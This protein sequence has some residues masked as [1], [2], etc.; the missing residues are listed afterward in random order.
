MLPLRSKESKNIFYCPDLGLGY[1]ASALR[2]NFKGKINV[3]LLINNLALSDEEFNKYLLKGN[4][5]LIGI[6][7][8]ST[9]VSSAKRTLLLIKKTLPKAKVVIGG[10]QP[11]GDPDNI[12][13]YI[14]SDYAF[15]GE[16]EIGFPQFVEAFGRNNSGELEESFKKEIPGLIWKKNGSVI[17]NPVKVVED[18]DSIGMPAWDLM[19]PKEFP[20]QRDYAFSYNYPISPFIASRGCSFKCTFCTAGSIKFRERS[21]ENVME[22]VRM[23]HDDFGVQEFNMIDNCC[24]YRAKYMID[25][26]E[27]L[28]NSKLNVTWN[29]SGGTRINSINPEML[30]W[31][32]KSRCNQIWVGIE[33]GSPRIL[34]KIKKGITLEQ[35]EEKVKLV[36]QARINISGYFMLGIPGETKEDIQKTIDFAKKLNLQGAVFNIFVPIPGTELYDELQR[37]GKITD[38]DFDLMDQKYYRNNFTEYS[39]EELIGLRVKA[40]WSFHLRPKVIFSKLKFFLGFLR[41]P[42][43]VYFWIRYVFWHLYLGRKAWK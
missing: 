41:R 42:K 23:L 29:A 32:K 13:S 39:P 10:P 11:T 4:F 18:L 36:N 33:S 28:I 27:A 43:K 37:E 38:S 17:R 14:L 25:F 35:V 1:L 34:K 20:Y 21:V 6:K 2:D 22:E 30:Y 31:L 16:A 7:V 24:G 26:C 5:D 40:Y 12:L 3:T 8:F 9:T 19:D 15:E